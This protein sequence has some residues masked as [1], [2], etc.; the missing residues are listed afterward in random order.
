MQHLHSAPTLKNPREFAVN[1]MAL[2]YGQN[3]PHAAHVRKLALQLFDQ[4]NGLH[5]YGPWER[6]LL[7]VAALLHDVGYIVNYY[8]HDKHSE[9][10]IADAELP[11]FNHREIA[12]IALIARYHRKGTPDCAPYCAVLDEDDAVRVTWLSACTRLAEYLERGRRQVVQSVTARLQPTELLLE[13]RT[14]GDASMEIYEAQ[15]ASKLL[16]K[17]VNRPVR[18]I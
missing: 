11:G 15:R 8:N 2:Q 10:L 12:I 16:A 17:L 14:K 18:V 9:Y 6:E 7:A 4:L 1:N 5:G 3:T 13:T